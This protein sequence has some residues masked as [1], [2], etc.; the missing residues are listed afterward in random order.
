MIRFSNQEGQVALYNLA[1]DVAEKRNL[2]AKH[3]QLVTE[4]CKF[5]EDEIAREKELPVVLKRLWLKR[6]QGT[7]MRSDQ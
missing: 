4:L 1:D 3:P 6:R 5:I 7:T 2:A